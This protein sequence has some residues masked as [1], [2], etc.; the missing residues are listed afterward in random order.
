VGIKFNGANGCG[1][2]SACIGPQASSIGAPV[3]SVFNQATSVGATSIAVTM[4]SAVTQGDPILV[5]VQAATVP[6]SVTDTIGNTYQLY[7][8]QT[9][10]NFGMWA[11]ASKDANNRICSIGSASASGNVVTANFAAQS[12]VATIVAVEYPQGQQLS[13]GIDPQVNSAIG[14][15]TGSTVTLGTSYYA[16]MV[17]VCAI[18]NSLTTS[19]S[20]G[21]GFTGRI[22][23]SG[24]LAA[25]LLEDQL[26]TT[27]TSVTCAASN[28]G[29]VASG[30]WT[31]IAL[32]LYCRSGPP[33]GNIVIMGW[34]KYDVNT[35]ESEWI[36]LGFNDAIGNPSVIGWTPIIANDVANHMLSGFPVGTGSVTFNTAVVVGEWTPFCVMYRQSGGDFH[37][38]VA[39]LGSEGVATRTDSVGAYTA[40]TCPSDFL[41]FGNE[42]T[43]SGGLGTPDGTSLPVMSNS[44]TASTLALAGIKIWTSTQ[45]TSLAQ[46]FSDEIILAEWRQL[47]PVR[48]QDLWA[49]WEFRGEGTSLN[50]SVTQGTAAGMTMAVFS[51]GN[52][53]AFIQDPPI[54]RTAAPSPLLFA[55]MPSTGNTNYTASISESITAPSDSVA[56]AFVGA[57]SIA[58]SITAPSDAAAR[59]FVGARSV[60]ESLTAPN[61][62]V[63]RLFVGARSIAESITAPTDSVARAFV[64]ARSIPESVT[65]PSDSIAR[66]QVLSRALSESITA[67]S[68]SVAVQRGVAR[69]VSESITAPSDGL[70]RAFT[71]ARSLSESVTAPSDSVA[72]AQ[73]LSRSLAESVTAP[74]DALTR[75]QGIGRAIAEGITAPSDGVAR[76]FVG[77]R[78]VA[79]SITAPSDS[80][81][82]AQV[83]ARSVAESVTA[84][85]DAISHS[86]VVTRSIS[87]S[88]TAP[89]D[90]LSRLFGALR[91]IAESITAPTDAVAR[92]FVG[93]RS[94]AETIPTHPPSDSVAGVSPGKR[95]I[96]ESITAPSDSVARAF[97]GARAIAESVTAPTDSINRTFVGSRSLSESVTAP[98]DSVARSQGLVRAIAESI[99]APTDAVA[100]AFVGHRAIAE[101]LAAPS[102]AVARLF[103]PTRSLS[104]NITTPSDSVAQ[105]FVH[106]RSLSESLATPGDALLR[107]AIV[108]RLLAEAL[109]TPTDLVTAVYTPLSG[110]ALDLD[111]QDSVLLD[112]DLTDAPLLTFGLTDV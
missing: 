89:S 12:T 47:E 4:T 42:Y 91:S 74:S 86:Q 57:R 108:S 73:V 5:F 19:S 83:L 39:H 107:A 8:A 32:G 68:D 77:A 100:R 29:A 87:E 99:G 21:S 3:Q 37:A 22:T 101:S 85:S 26:L 104:E 35:P 63:S 93:A 98:S 96:A 20:A 45:E 54:P 30:T 41:C 24:T 15:T 62:S 6:S 59:A 95:G 79:E 103:A 49:Y 81:A 10:G 40:L 64:G 72:R 7:R 110:G 33:S 90:V 92:Q 2:V 75:S 105:S 52:G 11:Y 58:E 111:L 66:T 44:Q 61:D 36:Q 106:T 109:G 14:T 84:P 18:G 67:P 34:V 16:E 69:A 25:V 78:S 97:I 102:D 31:T 82:R 17:V 56:R 70:T 80:I 46:L 65:A 48:K 43:I 60:N 50:T 51:A 1:L 88:V 13:F 38:R 71:G 9:N 23:A 53:G 112:L 76:A 28:I 55:R 27:P 94:I